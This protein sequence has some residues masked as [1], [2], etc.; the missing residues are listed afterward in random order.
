M[1][2]GTCEQKVFH[3]IDGHFRIWL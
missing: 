3:F 1:A 2:T